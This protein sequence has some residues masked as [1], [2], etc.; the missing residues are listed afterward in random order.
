MDR[1]KLINDQYGHEAG[2][3]VMKSYLQGVKQVVGVRGD[4]FRGLG[5][6]VKVLLTGTEHEENIRI[7]EEIRRQVSEMRLEHSAKRFLESRQ[8]LVFRLLRLTPV[9]VQLSRLPTSVSVLLS[10]RARTVWSLPD[11]AV[12][13]SHSDEWL[14]GL[15]CL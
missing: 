3:V 7:A 5:D 9:I 8:A 12:G 1:F 4:A 10:F 13:V 6:E 14:W 11:F 15:L 2:D